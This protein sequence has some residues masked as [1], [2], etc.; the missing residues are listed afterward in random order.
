MKFI[1]FFFFIF[2]LNLLSHGTVSSIDDVDD[3]ERY[4]VFPNTENYVVMSTD[5]HTHSVFSDGHVWPNLRVAEALRDG[6]DVIAITEHL[7]LQPHKNDIPHSDRNRAYEIAYDSA[8]DENLMVLNGTEITRKFPPG[9]INAVF[10]KD[11]NK[12]IFVDRSKQ[13]EVDDFIAS[14]PQEE[15]QDYI[16]EP[17]LNDGVLAAMWPIEET[18]LE[19]KN[20]DAFVFWNHPAWSSEEESSDKLL[21]DIH[22]E[23][24]NKNLIHGIEVVNG[25]WFSDEAFQIAIDYDL[26]IMG[27]S[28][29][30][31]L[32][33]WDYL[34]RPN[35]HR[36]VTLVLSEDRT[37]ASLKE[38]LFAGRTII[39]YK[40]NLIG[41]NENIVELIDAC[42]SI[43]N[44][45]FKGNT[46]VLL[47][48]IENVSDADFQLRV[49]DGKT[50]ENNPNIFS[51]SPNGITQVEIG[52]Q[53][54]TKIS[55]GLDVL[56]AF[57][58]PN[59]HPS[60]ILSN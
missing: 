51:I 10:V 29:V 42:L 6:I 3:S 11:A 13:N 50:V 41:R 1:I 2:S 19:A 52:N 58:A 25:I 18:L 24:F 43:K 33:D 9:H 59:K 30:H 55:L 31:G 34:Q 56:N 36:S 17:W 35:G 23:L 53:Q 5:L 21:H 7:E 37:Q 16:N 12:M 8:K 48:E 57:I 27:T 32:I 26:T 40:N 54:N 47:L 45:E 60:I 28:D 20:Q 46:N 22:I 49:N 4:I 38:A 44:A 15:V 39:W 14:L